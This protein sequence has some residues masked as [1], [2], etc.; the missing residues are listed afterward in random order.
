MTSQ[1]MNAR[2][3]ELSGQ[4]V[5]LARSRLSEWADSPEAIRAALPPFFTAIA[6]GVASILVLTCG[7]HAIA[8]AAIMTSQITEATNALVKNEARS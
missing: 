4:L 2:R 7:Q 5:D 6:H 8:A 1:Q 3:D